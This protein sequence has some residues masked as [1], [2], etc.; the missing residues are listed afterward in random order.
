[1]QHCGGG[2]AIKISDYVLSICLD[3]EGFQAIPHIIT[4]KDQ[5]MMVVI[6]GKRELCW[7]CKQ[8]DHH[9]KTCLQKT[10]KT[11]TT[12]TTTN[13]NKAKEATSGVTELGDQLDNQ[14]KGWN[15][16]IRKKKSIT[17]DPSTTEATAQSPS[18][19]PP[20]T[21]TKKKGKKRS[22]PGNNLRRWRQ[23]QT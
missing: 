22:Q 16:V 15:R 21:H 17:T 9:A 23:I 3:R 12:I 11:S 18:L 10:S 1:M 4:Y 14:E 6:E 19:S 7:A 20:H 2:D 8:L 5:H 13:H